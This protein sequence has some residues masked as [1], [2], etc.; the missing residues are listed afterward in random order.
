MY[1]YTS[2]FAIIY[3]LNLLP[4][5]APPTWQVVSL[6]VL[7]RPV[8]LPLLV[9]IAATAATLGRASL[10]MLSS[11]LIYSR[12]LND[13]SINNINQVRGWLLQHANISGT[14]FLFYAFSPLPSNNL[15][16]AYGLTNLPI[17]KIAI[18]FFIGRI[19]SYSFWAVSFNSLGSILINEQTSRY[20]LFGGY[21]VVTQIFNLLL[22]YGFVKLDWSSF[23]HR[24]KLQW[25]QK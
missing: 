11:R 21:F 9:V 16:I 2:I 23:I 14:M 15:F 4:A 1:F 8:L 18:P 6:S 17:G 22:V 12:F 13:T 10:A 3:L 24:R 7:S 19:V 5:F 20:E 25:L